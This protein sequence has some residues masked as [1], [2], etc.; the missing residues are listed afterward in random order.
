MP[1]LISSFTPRS[2]AVLLSVFFTLGLS[3]CSHKPLHTG[4]QGT[5]STDKNLET[6]VIMGFNDIHG[7]LTP[8]SAKTKE[9]PGVER[10]SYEKGG[11]AILASHIKVLR[12][13]FGPHLLILDGGDEFQGSI[14]SNF[15][16]GAPMVQ[17]FNAIGLNAAVLGNHEFDFGVDSLKKR[18]SEAHYPYLA[19]NVVEKGSQKFPGVPGTLPSAMLQAGRLKIG[20]IGLT[21]TDTP[22]TTRQEFVRDVEFL[23]L[24]QSALAE[25]DRLKKDGANMVIL[26]THEGLFCDVGKKPAKNTAILRTSNDQQTECRERDKI[27]TLLHALPSGT[28]DAVVSG[29]SHS[30]VHH[31]VAGIPV[32]QS[33]TRN[34]YYN[35]IYLTYDWSLHKPVFERTRIEGPVPVC[36]KI[37]ENQK[38]CNGDRT[39]P[40]LG[41]GKLVDAVFHG[42]TIEPDPV[43]TAL[44]QPTFEKTA[45][46]KK[47]IVGL[48]AR[49]I[50]HTRSGESPFG[51]L[52]ADALKDSVHADVVIMNGGGIRTSIDSGPITYGSVFRALP[53]DNSISV[54]TVN[55]KELKLALRIAESGSRG[56]FPVSGV[57]LRLI[58]SKYEAH[59]DDLSGDKAI[60]PWEINRLIE[61]VL[62]DAAGNE[63]PISDTKMYRLGTIDFLVTGGDDFAWYMHQ[64][65][66]SRI[67]LAAGPVLREAVTQYITEKSAQLAQFG[68]LNS[69]GHPLVDPAHLRL[70]FEKPP[71]KTKKSGKRRS[72]KRRSKKSKE[73]IGTAAGT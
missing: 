45:T 25:S 26:L 68:G 21:T 7:A 55:G 62:V 24:K 56:I 20:V 71:Q 47:R 32:I 13:E 3:A 5:L 42:E 19:A 23:N 35:L 39:P 72:K 69:E 46:A 61:A 57:K 44:L 14:E 51:N 41:R 54:L 27:V 6:V 1:Q 2:L 11:A 28:V 16:Q 73:T 8:E 63:S 37:F 4:D 33:G 48:A 65:P 43:V 66:E 60:A 53:F 15:E 34:Q 58:D 10:I 9:A 36:P 29:H 64:I 67:Q 40:K 49:G 52:V 12:Q 70:V 17:F 18:I 22:A 38:D 30:L 31:W 59:A 50:E